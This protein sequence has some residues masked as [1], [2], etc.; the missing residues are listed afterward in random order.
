MRWCRNKLTWCIVTNCL[1]SSLNVIVHLSGKVSL[2]PLTTGPLGGSVYWV[3]LWNLKLAPDALPTLAKMVSGSTS[4]SERAFIVT[5]APCEHTHKVEGEKQTGTCLKFKVRVECLL[6]SLSFDSD[7]PW[8]NLLW[9]SNGWH[10]FLYESPS[11][12]HL[13]RETHTHLLYTAKFRRMHMWSHSWDTTLGGENSHWPQH[14]K[15]LFFYLKKIPSQQ[16]KF[17]SADLFIR[18]HANSH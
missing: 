1:Y 2:C 8:E 17:L 16:N 15:L 5:W 7:S 9:R 14:F 13:S 10:T 18:G 3:C 4:S 12:P 6:Y 11:H